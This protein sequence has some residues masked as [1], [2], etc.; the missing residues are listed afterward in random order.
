IQANVAIRPHVA[1]N[2]EQRSLVI[3][4]WGNGEISRRPHLRSSSFCLAATAPKALSVNRA[5]LLRALAGTEGSAMTDSMTTESR[6]EALRQGANA[7][8]SIV[9][10]PS[11]AQR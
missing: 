3:K 8:H 1:A 6:S 4:G 10:R 11:A 9:S 2:S 5:V 7:K